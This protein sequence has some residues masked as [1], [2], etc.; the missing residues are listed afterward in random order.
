MGEAEDKERKIDANRYRDSL[1]K[2]Q[3]VFA[4]ISRTVT[5]VSKWR[6]PYKDAADLCTAQLRCRN[7]VRAAQ[8]GMQILRCAGNHLNFEAVAEE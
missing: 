8:G 5:E 6:C 7:Q 2:L 3:E 1:A 4:G